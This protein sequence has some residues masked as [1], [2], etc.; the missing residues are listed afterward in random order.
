MPA[1]ADTTHG[2]PYLSGAGRL[3]IKDVIMF[4]AAV[5]TLADSAKA[6][7]SRSSGIGG[8]AW[9]GRPSPH[10]GD[11]AL[12]VAYIAKWGETNIDD[13]SRKVAAVFRASVPQDADCRGNPKVL[14]R[15]LSHSIQDLSTA[16]PNDLS[17]I[18]DSQSQSANSIPN[19]SHRLCGPPCVTALPRSRRDLQNGQWSSKNARSV[20]CQRRS[21]RRRGPV[22][23][24]PDTLTLSTS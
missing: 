11:H 24:A 9:Q 3:I 7:L 14:R 8:S 15:M 12:G 16:S 5:V 10:S 19:L 2:F 13:A 23:S 1:V 4:G 22:L 17:L 21:G 18:L 20:T 6:Y